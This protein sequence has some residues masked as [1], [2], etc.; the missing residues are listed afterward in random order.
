ML[1]KVKDLKQRQYFTLKEIKEP[2]DNQVWV[3]GEYD[4]HTKT[5]SAINF[6]DVNKER[7][8]K[9]NKEV[10]VDFIF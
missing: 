1:M 10:Y 3:R 2:K 4:R 6:S 5:Y 8:F 7:F 9:G